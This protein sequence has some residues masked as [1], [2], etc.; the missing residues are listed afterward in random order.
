[1]NKY[2]VFKLPKDILIETANKHRKLRK[3]RKLS[4]AQ[5]AERSG[6]FI[7]EYQTI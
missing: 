4:Q 3:Q 7:G 2:S 5:L 6:V 1:M